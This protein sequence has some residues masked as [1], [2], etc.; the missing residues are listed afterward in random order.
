MLPEAEAPLWDIESLIVPVLATF[1]M[2]LLRSF[3]SLFFE[4]AVDPHRA[5]GG[6][7]ILEGGDP[8]GEVAGD[9]TQE[10]TGASVV[11]RAGRGGAALQA[12]FLLMV[13]APGIAGPIHKC[14]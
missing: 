3:D 14:G 9:L 5:W 8:V 12:G 11:L 2:D 4:D 7:A 13:V 1:V 10:S 6:Q